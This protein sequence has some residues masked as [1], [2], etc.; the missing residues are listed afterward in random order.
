M[1]ARNYNARE[2][3]K[4]GTA[5]TIRAI[6][7]GDRSRLLEAFKGLDRESVYRRFFSPKKELSDRE[8]DQL[9]DVDFSQVVALVVTTQGV[10]D[11]ILIGGG[12]YATEG[13]VSDQ[14]EIAFVTDGSYRGRGI[15]SLILKHLVRI[16]RDAEVQ[17]F[18]AE[19]LAE[20]APMLAVFRRCG[21]PVKL[22]RDGSTVHL[23][24]SLG[25]RKEQ[26]HGT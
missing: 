5:V 13:A 23:T 1:D 3:L 11:E 8:L 15:A 24:L 17:H 26:R 14:A 2:I 19:V 16:A 20:N 4:D 25:S 18:D 21:L 9:T 12:R 10:D 22:R 6:R 7:R